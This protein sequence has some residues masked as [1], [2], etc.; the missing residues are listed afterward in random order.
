MRYKKLICLQV[1]SYF[2]E[3]VIIV[4]VYQNWLNCFH[5]LVFVGG[6]FAFQLVNNIFNC[7]ARRCYQDMTST[8]SFRVHPD[9]GI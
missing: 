2:R 1:Y 5:F 6:I 4:D 3:E 9:P 8:G 7:Q